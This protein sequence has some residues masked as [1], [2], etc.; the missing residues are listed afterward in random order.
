M[1]YFGSSMTAPADEAEPLQHGKAASCSC[2]VCGGSEQ[3]PWK[4][5]NLSSSELRPEDFHI[6]D[7][8]YG[9]TLPLVRC[10]DCEFIFATAAGAAGIIAL[11]EQM[12]DPDYDSS[13]SARRFQMEWVIREALRSTPYAKTLLDIGA[14]TGMLVAEAQKQGLTAC[15]V[16]PSHALSRL[17]VERG[18]EVVQGTYPHRELDG[19]K[20]DLVCLV[21]VIEHVED[22]AELLR[23]AASALAPNGLLVVITPDISS[24]AARVLGKRWW[25][26]RLAHIGY[27]TPKTFA[28][29]AGRCGLEITSTERARWFFPVAYLADRLAV[30]LP[31]LGPLNRWFRKAPLFRDLFAKVIPLNLFDS[32]Y[33]LLGNGRGSDR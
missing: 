23:A 17:A 11:Y 33:F 29:L 20:F 4:Q 15:G 13:G 1:S 22:P 9:V 32:S 5:G 16:E 6:T 3:S 28:R 14:G 24:V 8:R 27:F 18:L 19:R 30:Y 12:E 21:D 2:P 26:L 31:F 7:A 25:H 10:K